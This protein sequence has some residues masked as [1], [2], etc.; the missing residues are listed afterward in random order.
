MLK[1]GLKSYIIASN[2][3]E[4]MLKFIKDDGGVDFACHTIQSNECIR[5]VLFITE[6]IIILGKHILRLYKKSYNCL[7]IWILTKFNLYSG[8]KSY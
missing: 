8:I 4:T 1:R 7:E 6:I 2:I 5:K 3:Y